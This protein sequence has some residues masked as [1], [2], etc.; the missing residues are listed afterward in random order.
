MD[1]AQ[2]ASQLSECYN[3]VN[4]LITNELVRDYVPY[5]WTT[6]IHV[7]KE[8]YTGLAHFHAAS[9]ILHKDTNKLTNT[10]RDSLLNIHEGQ[11]D[12]ISLQTTEDKRL[13]GN[14]ILYNE[15][16]EIIG[17]ENIINYS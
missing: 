5:S 6:L 4:Q 9:G 17:F 1:L 14:T 15:L 7:K 8:Y 12:I 13:L 16:L 3:T 10:T 2:E 11:A